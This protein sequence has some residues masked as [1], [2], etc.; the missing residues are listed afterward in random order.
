MIFAQWLAVMI[1]PVW[2]QGADMT[3]CGLLVLLAHGSKPHHAEPEPVAA[4]PRNWNELWRA[5]ELEPVVVV[6]LVLTAWLYLRGVRRVW[7]QAGIGHGVRRWEAASFAGGWLA[8]V[9]ALVSP[10]HPWGNVLFSA[11]MMQ[12]EVLM[13]VAAPLLVLGKPV[14]AFLKA[15]PMGWVRLLLDSMRPVWVQSVWRMLTNPFVA[16]LV[17]ARRVVGLA[18]PGAVHRGARKRV[19]PCP[20]APQFL[21]NGA[22]VLVG[23]DPWPRAGDGLR[24]G[25]ALHVHHGNTQW[26]SRGAHHARR[27]RLVPG[28]PRANRS[29]GPNPLEDQ[30]LGGLIMWVPAC[31]LYIVAGLA[32]FAGWL[33]SSEER[34]RQWEPATLPARAPT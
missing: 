2:I 9:V 24:C 10:L 20:P 5:W 28:L 33:R 3:V 30:Q 6:S 26:P 32:F 11:H 19:R 34:V 16:W 4:G 22:A 21:A 15:L 7:R 14:V 13:L 17:H 8:L 27:P 23:G 29:V 18:H 25:G 31:S 1:L 12:H